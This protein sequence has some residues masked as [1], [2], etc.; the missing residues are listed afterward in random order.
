MRMHCYHQCT[1]E[2]QRTHN[3]QFRT[4]AGTNGYVAN[5]RNRLLSFAMDLKGKLK[6][7]VLRTRVV[8]CAQPCC[9]QSVQVSSGPV[10]LN[11]I[12]WGRSS[13]LLASAPKNKTYFEH[14]QRHMP[15][16]GC[17]GRLTVSQGSLPDAS[18][19]G[20]RSQQTVPNSRKQA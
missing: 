18:L 12:T 20:A 1:I 9:V 14:V 10:P 4:A 2:E 16:R 19:A 17:P 11:S 3:W 15:H 5:T 8:C 6:C 13:K 7:G